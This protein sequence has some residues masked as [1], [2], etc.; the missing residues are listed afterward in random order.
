MNVEE[1]CP[2]LGKFFNMK[3]LISILF[4][5]LL[6]HSLHAQEEVKEIPIQFSVFTHSIA[7]PFQEPI[8]RPLNGGFSVGF[9]PFSKTGKFISRSMDLNLSWYRHKE[10]GQGLMLQSSLI[11]EYVHKSGLRIGPKISF[12]YLHT[13]NEKALYQINSDGTYERVRD[14]GR[15][16]LALGAGARLGFDFG[17]NS[18]TPL[19][20]FIQ[21]EWVGQI[22]HSRF[23]ILFPH[24]FVHVGLVYSLSSK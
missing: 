22:P 17:K 24:S 14:R 15:S 4:Y 9:T 12:G 10:L 13:F 20:P 5:W 7:M 1:S 11:S 8:K 6:L 3:Y 18:K 2:Y 19:R 16:S 23:A 21:Y